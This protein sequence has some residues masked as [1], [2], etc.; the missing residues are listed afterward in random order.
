MITAGGFY[1]TIYTAAQPQITSVGTL[2]SLNVNG[3]VGIG[4][5]SPTNKLEVN[6]VIETLYNN[7]HSGSSLK[8]N[9]LW[10]NNN[11][12]FYIQYSSSGKLI[13]CQGG[14]NVGIGTSSPECPLH[15]TKG[16]QSNLQQ[17]RFYASWTNH[18]NAGLA[19]NPQ[20]INIGIKSTYGIWTNGNLWSA[21][22]YS[23]IRIKENIIDVP[24]AL[25]LQK[26]RDISCS[27]YEYKDKL[28]R[29]Y[30]QVIGFIAQQVKEH[31]PM[32]VTT[33]ANIIPNEMRNLQDISWIGTDMSCNLTDV[34]GIK[35]CFYVS[36]DVS[37][38]D[39]IMKEVI[40]NED[41]TFTF[42]TSYNN[43][44]CYGKEVDDFHILK[45]DKL[46]ALNFSATQEIDKIQQE[47][48]A[49]LAAAE[50]EITTLKDKVTSLETTIT[51]LV[52]RLTALETA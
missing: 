52:A 26:L 8:D 7:A 22:D 36:N 10:R 30:D 2:S 28:K 51:D 41:N 5:T 35:Y 32:A 46:F 15:V 20:N 16:V 43:V 29:G 11:G 49:K 18:G 37:N 1:G 33:A 45:K 4:T 31:L 14:G 47:E 50:T 44:F 42:D 12:D 3:N 48:K 25:S 9:E 34:S 39:E 6:G 21:D 24:D 27:Y 23:D 13:L 19:S 17:A 40:G 38:N